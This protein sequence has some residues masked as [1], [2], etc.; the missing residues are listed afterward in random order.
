MVAGYHYYESVGERRHKA[1]DVVEGVENGRVR[2]PHRVKHVAGD[3]HKFRPQRDYCV[4]RATKRGRN[5]G[6]TLVNASGSETLKL[7]EP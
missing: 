3:E 1:A 2:G 6:L 7:T 4:N 5:V